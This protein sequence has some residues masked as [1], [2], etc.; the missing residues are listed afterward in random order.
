[1]LNDFLILII[2]KN[3]LGQNALDL[4]MT[5]CWYSLHFLVLIC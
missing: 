5:K 1:L 3:Q 4:L 2:F